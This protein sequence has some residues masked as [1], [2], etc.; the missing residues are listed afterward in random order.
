[1]DFVVI[2]PSQLENPINH[3]P[4]LCSTHIIF[5]FNHL[6]ETIFDYDSIFGQDTL[7]LA[8]K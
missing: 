7:L 4:A 1:M 8:I 2:K 5:I 3:G 6:D